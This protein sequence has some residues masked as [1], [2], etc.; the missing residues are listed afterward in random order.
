MAISRMPGSEAQA[1][2][3]TASTLSH[4]QDYPAGEWQ[5]WNEARLYT[6]F[7]AHLQVEENYLKQTYCSLRHWKGEK[8]SHDTTPCISRGKGNGLYMQE[9][10]WKESD[11]ETLNHILVPQFFGSQVNGA[12]FY[13]GL[14][15]SLGI[16]HW[17]PINK[18]QQSTIK[19]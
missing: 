15:F 3:H 1:Q 18:L 2:P 13:Q 12:L 17:N 4:L 14:W 10:W 19:E 8:S 6:Y 11:N 16:S 9:G 7:L 5:T